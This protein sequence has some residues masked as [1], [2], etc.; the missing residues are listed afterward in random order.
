MGIVLPNNTDRVS[1]NVLGFDANAYLYGTPSTLSQKFNYNMPNAQ[2]D[3]FTSSQNS[4]TKVK[5]KAIGAILGGAALAGLFLLAGKLNLSL[6]KFKK[7]DTSNIDIKKHTKAT[8]GFLQKAFGG[9]KDAFK[10][11]FDVVFKNYKK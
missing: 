6:P 5:D 1:A 4:K 3:C 9:I 8:T 7:I 2:N 11:S 10:N